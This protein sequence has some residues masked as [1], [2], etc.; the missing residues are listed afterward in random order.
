MG[1]LYLKKLLLCVVGKLGQGKFKI[2]KR[3]SRSI[4]LATFIDLFNV[5]MNFKPKD[6]ICTVLRYDF[7]LIA[8]FQDLDKKVLT[9]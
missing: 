7:K 3:K 4:S 5:L 6:L 2:D 9:L 1:N 8:Y